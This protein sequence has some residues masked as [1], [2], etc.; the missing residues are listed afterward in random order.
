MLFLTR[1][2]HYCGLNYDRTVM[3]ICV[4]PN[5]N[6]QHIH[7]LVE[8][9]AKAL[10]TIACGR[11]PACVFMKVRT[12]FFVG[13]GR[14]FSLHSIPTKGA[15]VLPPACQCRHQAIC[16]RWYLLRSVELD[17]CVFIPNTFP[18]REV[19]TRAASIDAGDMTQFT[20]GPPQVQGFKK[21][22]QTI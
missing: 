7:Y 20:Y 18:P 10:D 2:R 19:T 1:Y 9:S 13:K 6:C 8:A 21:K 4:S 16:S 11:F 14:K 22:L 15:W 12:M 3:D 5:T 17:E